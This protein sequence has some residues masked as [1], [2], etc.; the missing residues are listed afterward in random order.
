MNELM[1]DKLDEFINE[2][3]NNEEF[4]RLKELKKIID[5]ELKDEIKD[6]NIASYKLEEAS[7]YG[8]YHPDLERL[9]KDLSLK[10]E[11]LYSNP[12]VKEYLKLERLIQNELDSFTNEM[13]LAISNK[14]GLK[15]IL[16]W[17]KYGRKNKCS[18][19][20]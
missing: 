4:K 1:Y 18:Y 12:L 2:F 8:K 9:R 14:I 19:I 7:K 16:S 3:I 20:L 15:K 10:K 13:A 11:A 6:F 17:G 5:L